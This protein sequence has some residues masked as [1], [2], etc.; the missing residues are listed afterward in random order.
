MIGDDV[1]IGANT[2]IDRGALDDTVIEEGVKLDNL[3]QIAHNCRDRRPHRDRRLRRHRRQHAHRPP[4]HVRRRGDD[5]RPHRDRRRRDH[6]RRELRRAS[7]SGS[8]AP[9]PA[10]FR[11]QT[12][13]DWLRNF[14]HL[15]HLRRAG[16]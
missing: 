13:E 14:A 12:H 3:V 4:L 16:G 5:H 15:R 10:R 2:T 8:P 6:H 7:R 11:S 1:E 9:I